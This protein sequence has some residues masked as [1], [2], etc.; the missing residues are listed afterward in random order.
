MGYLSDGMA[1]LLDT[2]HGAGTSNGMI[3]MQKKM[4][5]TLEAQ[6]E[7]ALSE[8]HRQSLDKSTA[9]AMKKEGVTEGV[10]MTMQ[11]EMK[12]K[13]NRDK[14]VFMSTTKGMSWEPSDSG[15]TTVYNNWVR[16]FAGTRN[17]KTPAYP[18]ILD[19]SGDLTTDIT[20]DGSAYT[21]DADNGVWSYD[22]NKDPHVIKRGQLVKL[23][24]TPCFYATPAG[25][26]GWRFKIQRIKVL[27]Q[28]PYGTK[29]PA[30]EDWGEDDSDDLNSYAKHA[31]TE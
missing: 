4:H 17:D 10:V 14:N 8:I 28:S 3:E 21:Y 1:N 11:K 19:K 25:A 12:K 15:I 31:R 5:K 29:R 13:H 22:A 23:Q 26:R 6:L 24:L 2:E 7:F 20:P 30:E 18:H 16:T 9:E 27:L